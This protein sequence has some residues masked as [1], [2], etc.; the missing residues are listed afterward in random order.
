MWPAPSSLPELFPL[1]KGMSPAATLEAYDWNGDASEMAS[2]A[3]AGL[4]LSNHSYGTITG[5]REDFSECTSH[6]WTWFGDPAISTTEDYYFGFYNSEAQSWDTIAYNA[7]YYLIV[8]SAGNDRGEGPGSGTAHCV[9]DDNSNDWVTSTATRDL[10]CDPLGYDCISTNGTAK[11][12]LTVGA[13][14]DIIGGYSP[15]AAGSVVMSDF[16]GWGPTDDGRIKPDLVANGIGLYSTDDVSN[17][18]Y[19]T[20]S[21]TSMSAPNVTGSLLLLQQHYQDINSISMR[22]S[23]LKAL[24]LHTADEAGAAPGPDYE[25]GWGLLNTKAAAE[26]ISADGNGSHQIIEASL[27]DGETYTVQVNSG[28]FG[29]EIKATLVWTDP[30]GTPPFPISLDPTDTMLVND[31]DLRIDGNSNTYEPWVLDPENPANPATT[32]DNYRDNVEQVQVTVYFTGIYTIE[33]S[34]KGTLADPQSFSLIISTQP[35]N[36]EFIQS[37]DFESGL[38]TGWEAVVNGGSDN[39]WVVVP[40][41]WNG[42]ANDTGG[43]G[44]FA[45]ADS[46][47]NGASDTDLITE[48]FDFSGYADVLLRFKSHVSLPSPSPPDQFINEYT[49]VDVSVDGDAWDNVWDRSG[50]TA[51]APGPS[52]LNIGISSLADNQADV[53]VRFHKEDTSYSW[54]W[55][56]DD[57]T[58]IGTPAPSICGDTYSLPQGEWRLISLPCDPG[59]NNTVNDLFG[60]DF[61]LSSYGVTWIMYERYE[62]SNEYAVLGPDSPLYQGEG[63]WIYTTESDVSLDMTGTETSLPETVGCSDAS[64]FAIPLTPPTP[65]A[66]LL[67]NMKGHPMPFSVN[68]ADVRVRTGGSSYTPTGADGVNYLSKTFYTY[69]GNGYDSYDDGTTPGMEGILGGYSGFWVEVLEDAPGDLTLLIPPTRSYGMILSGLSP[70]NDPDGPQNLFAF[71]GNNSFTAMHFNGI[72]SWL[73]AGLDWLVPAAHAAPKKEDKKIPPGLA[74]RDAHRAAH[75]QKIARNEEW[76]V[77]LKVEAQGE[78]LRDSNNVFGQLA[79]SGYGYDEH[80]LKEI[81]PFDE[82]YLTVV[83]PHPDWDD[84]AHDYASDFH[85]LGKGKKGDSWRFEVRTDDPNREL[86]LTWSGPN[87]I[88]RNS[89]LVD[90]STGEAVEVIPG[91]GYTFVMNATSRTFIWEFSGKSKKYK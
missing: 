75:K 56:V 67:M 74:K 58:L 54:Y 31:L 73:N 60:D 65:P 44:D 80:D 21:G 84:R 90:E 86:T 43:T 14:G 71:S 72:P 13:V 8:K 57:I 77:R 36:S 91:A 42:L 79:D 33:V 64:C 9:W 30:P 41:G 22:A 47:Y 35:R 4:L 69:N 45:I 3:G 32:G 17:T 11:N 40:S 85:P 15:A 62:E 78:D 46:I 89:W 87:E 37:Y 24:A 20:L 76:Y 29:S 5:W 38:P 25:F 49:N 61:S 39:A 7:P 2:A 19:T 52:T 12:I 1:P 59:S 82:T 28:G 23:T 50:G 68:W 70:E 48:S 53:Q 88:L 51:Y 16:S 6:A 83:F 66:T 63:Y 81:P 18:A 10:D 26:V 27:A 55:Q 34:H